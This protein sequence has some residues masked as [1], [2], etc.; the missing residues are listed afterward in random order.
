MIFKLQAQFNR[1]VSS[2]QDRINKNNQG[3]L[4]S[5]RF[6]ANSQE[7][8]NFIEE[9]IFNKRLQNYKIK[10]NP[11]IIL[12]ES[13]GNSLANL[14]EEYQNISPVLIFIHYENEKIGIFS[15]NIFK[16][17]LEDGSWI[18][19]KN[20]FIFSIDKKKIYKVNEFEEKAI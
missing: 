19:D 2:I 9:E 3:I 13:N 4:Y 14:F 10:K 7:E 11:Y 12:K 6:F 8:W 18:S 16:G 15:E 5:N 17:D 20:S 1:F